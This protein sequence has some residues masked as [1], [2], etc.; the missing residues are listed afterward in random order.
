MPRGL[1]VLEIIREESILVKS[2][3]VRLDLQALFAERA[4]I[5]HC[6]DFGRV[7]GNSRITPKNYQKLNLPSPKLW[8]FEIVCCFFASFA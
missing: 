5:Q 3:F 8:T 2:S 4:I 6:L 1:H 7:W